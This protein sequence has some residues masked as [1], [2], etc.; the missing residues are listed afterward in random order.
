[1]PKRLLCSR[2]D[3]Y[4]SIHLSL[5]VDLINQHLNALLAGEKVNTPNYDMKTGY[6]VRF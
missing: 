1:M 3:S 4:I 6:R 5:D 2:V